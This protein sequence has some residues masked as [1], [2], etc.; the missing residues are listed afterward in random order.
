MNGNKLNINETIFGFSSLG[1]VG[2][3]IVKKIKRFSNLLYK[4]K[5][6]LTLKRLPMPSIKGK[7]KTWLKF[8]E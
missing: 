4:Q 8:H 1:D 2:S 3:R 6:S 7:R 5:I